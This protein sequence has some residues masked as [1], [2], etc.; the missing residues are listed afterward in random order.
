MPPLWAVNHHIPLVNPDKQHTYHLPRCPDALKPQ[1][2]DKI[3]TYEDAKWWVRASVPQAAPMLCIPKKNGKLRTVVDCRKRND[4]TV[5]D[6]TPFPDQD[7][8]RMDVARAKIRSKIDM[9]NAYEQVRVD[10]ADVVSTAFATV[11]GTF[12]SNV[13]QQGDC[14]APATFQRLMTTIFRDYIGV[15]MHVYLDDMFVFSDTIEEHE[16]HLGMVFEKLREA[17]LYLEKEKCDLYSKRMDCLG[18][19]VDNKGLHADSDKMARICAWRAMR[20]YHEVQRFLGL[21]EYLAQFM[22]DVSAYTSPLSGMTKN[23]HAFYWRPLH[24]K[25]LE[26]IKA[27]ACKSPILRPINPKLLE[28]IWLICDASASGLGAYYGQGPD[29]RTCRPAGFMS[30][31]LSDAQHHYAVHEREVLAILEALLKWEDKLLGYKFS[32]VTD[33]ESLE[34]F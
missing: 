22:P 6:V 21:V 7:Q 5:K 16:E 25:C 8:I 3:C 10:P 26:Y 34:F 17:Q 13:M 28:A 30:K 20:S 19:V 15:F 2:M 27:L 29:W 23:G 1:L 33:H 4:N 14:N 12:L 11:Y 9:A 24:D 31:K 18:H 32:I